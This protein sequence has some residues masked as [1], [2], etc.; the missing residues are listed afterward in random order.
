[1]SLTS[2][3]KT[4][5]SIEEIVNF[6][7]PFSS[8]QSI[9]FLSKYTSD[10]ISKLSPYILTLLRMSPFG[11]KLEVHYIDHPNETEEDIN[12]TRIDLKIVLIT[13]KLQL[14]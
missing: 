12:N 1:M 7:K 10:P 3:Q 5:L 8:V 2:F 6:E 13:I 14:L 9:H 4:S 11:Y